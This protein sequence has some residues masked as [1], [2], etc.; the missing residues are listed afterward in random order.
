[1]PLAPPVFQQPTL[2]TLPIELPPPAYF[3]FSPIPSPTT[4]LLHHSCAIPQ[5]HPPLHLSSIGLP[6]TQQGDQGPRGFG[7]V[8]QPRPDVR[9][10]LPPESVRTPRTG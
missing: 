2:V 8:H 9:Q 10:G 3:T 4:F 5:A 6:Q 1:M 7:Q